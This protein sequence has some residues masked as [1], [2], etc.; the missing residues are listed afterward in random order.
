MHCGKGVEIAPDKSNPV[1]TKVGLFDQSRLYV[2]R[3]QHMTW[4]LMNTTYVLSRRSVPSSIHH[5]HNGITNRDHWRRS[6]VASARQSRLR[7]SECFVTP[8]S[9]RRRADTVVPGTSCAFGTSATWSMTCSR[10]HAG[11][12]WMFCCRLAV[13]RHYVCVSPMNNNKCGFLI[14]ILPVTILPWVACRVGL[15]AISSCSSNR[16]RRRDE[17]SFFET[18]YRLSLLLHSINQA[19]RIGHA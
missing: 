10:I 8:K 5:H 3:H 6:T 2:D 16:G 18:I 12:H 11:T 14:H 15:A 9:R 7:Q 13:L 4:R 1:N 17:M 19:I